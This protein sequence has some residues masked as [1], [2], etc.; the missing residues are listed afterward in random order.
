MKK[1]HDQNILRRFFEPS[2]KVLLYNSRLHPFP[3]KLRS[4]WTDPFIVR[5]VFSYGA[6]EIED[7]KNGSTFKVNGQRLKPFLEL[8]S[9]E[10]LSSGWKVW[11]MAENL[12]L[13]GGNPHHFSLSFDSISCVLVVIFRTVS[14][15]QVWGSASLACVPN[16]HHHFGIVSLATLG[17]MCHSSLGVG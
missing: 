10:S 4:R 1:V 16:L 2:Q 8:Q 5:S 12:A 14:A 7:P 13:V 9:S 3:G 15:V 6:I 11:L 17:T